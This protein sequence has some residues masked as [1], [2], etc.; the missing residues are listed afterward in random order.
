MFNS[1]GPAE[2]IIVLVIALLVLGPKRLPSAA[3][4][5]GNAMREFKSAVTGKHGS[6][7]DKSIEAPSK[8]SAPENG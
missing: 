1:V 5:L 3:A 7:D 2:L 4:S 8:S 6:D